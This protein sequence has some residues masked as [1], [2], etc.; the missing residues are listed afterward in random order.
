MKLIKG[1]FVIAV[2]GALTF[3][4]DQTKKEATD[5]VDAVEVGL[6]AL[7]EYFSVYIARLHHAPR[8]PG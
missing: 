4:C 7:P 2:V 3:S 5:A 6:A 1:I 8:H